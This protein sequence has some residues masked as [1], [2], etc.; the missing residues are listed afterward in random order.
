MQREGIGFGRFKSAVL[1]LI[2]CGCAYW[3]CLPFFG[4]PLV[5]EREEG[6]HKFA[7]FLSV[8]SKQ[9]C[10]YTVQGRLWHLL[11]RSQLHWL[12]HMALFLSRP[13][14]PVLMHHIEM[15]CSMSHSPALFI[16]P[17]WIHVIGHRKESACLLRKLALCHIPS[18]P[19]SP[20]LLAVRKSSPEGS[21]SGWLYI[22]C[23]CICEGKWLMDE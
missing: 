21:Y 22:I 15:R 13:V 9:A 16:N 10:E 14:C 7:L 17:S 6:H 12:Y 8:T 11:L 1:D 20:C 23:Q 4:F 18:M 3:S 19:P 2:N 5:A